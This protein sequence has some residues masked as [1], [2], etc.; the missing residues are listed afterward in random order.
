MRDW[1]RLRRDARDDSQQDAR[2][3][4]ETPKYYPHL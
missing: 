1:T 4:F 2:S 3:T